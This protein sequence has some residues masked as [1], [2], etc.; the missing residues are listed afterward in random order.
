MS[1]VTASFFELFGIPG[2]SGS[3]QHV[4]ACTILYCTYMV[5]GTCSYHIMIESALS[6]G[7]AFGSY[8]QSE[9]ARVNS[10][11]L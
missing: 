9:R 11:C 2:Y 7:G 3:I 6:P 5:L 8:A 1:Y 10:S 4:L